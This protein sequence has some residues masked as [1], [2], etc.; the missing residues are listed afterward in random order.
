MPPALASAARRVR[1]EARA[2]VMREEDV[3]V[4]GRIRVGAGT[5]GSGRGASGT[6]KSSRPLLVPEGP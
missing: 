5:S 3:V 2:V 1:R 6:S 4:L